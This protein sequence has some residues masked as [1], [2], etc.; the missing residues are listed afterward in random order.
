MPIRVRIARLGSL[1]YPWRPWRLDWDRYGGRALF[2]GLPRFRCLAIVYRECVEP[3]CPCKYLEP[4][5]CSDCY[6]TG[7]LHL[8][9]PEH[10]RI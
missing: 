2:L 5:G 10:P 3:C 9:E 7:H 1:R 6:N 4:Y 8:F